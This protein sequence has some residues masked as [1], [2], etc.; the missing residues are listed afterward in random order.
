MFKVLLKKVILKK[1][2]SRIMENCQEKLRKIAPVWRRTALALLPIAAVLF[3]SILD[4]AAA[5]VCAPAMALVVSVQGMVEVR[6]AKGKN[7]QTVLL[8]DPLCP[9]DIIRVRDR[10]RAAV[11]FNNET[12]LR[13]D[14]KTTL[15]LDSAAKGKTTLIE[16]MTGAIHVLTRTPKPFKINTPFLNAGIDGTEFSIE[17]EQDQARLVM[18]EGKVSA[19][20][21][22]GSVILI[23][24]EAV[25]APRN[26]APRKEAVVRP[27]D[28]VQ[29]ALYYPTIINSP[30]DRRAGIEP[31]AERLQASVELYQHGRMTEALAKLDEI[32][33][34]EH[35]PRF[36]TYRAGLLLSVGRVD[37]ARAQIQQAAQLDPRNSNVHALK[38][39]IA[40]VKN[41]KEQARALAARAVELDSFSATARL[42]LS[43]AQQA[44]F[45]IEEAVDSVKRAVE[46][47]PQNAL[48][49]ARLAELHMSN[50]YLDRALG[51][52][53]HAVSLNPHLGKTQTVL[54]FTYLVQIDTGGA[55]AAFS[56]AIELDQADPMPRLGMGLAKIR[57]GDLETGRIE[58]EIAASLD[59]GNSLIRSYL[60]KAYFEEKRYGLA[61]TQ[62]DLAKERD[63]YDPTPWLYDGIMKQ[64]QNQP[65]EALSDIQK[66]I[67]LN[68]NRA[69][70][71]SRLL[72]DQDEAARGSSLARIY[73]NLEFEKRAI[74]E[75][76][77]SLSLDP[78]SHSAHRFLSDT[79]ADIPRH[80]TARISELLQAQLLQPININPVQPRLAVADLNIITSTGPAAA[81]FNEF[82]PLLERNKPQF[83]A[84]GILGSRGTA[85]EEAVFSALYRRASVSLGQFHY[86]T[87]GFRPNNDQ[88][89]NIYNAFF[90]YAVTPKFN[91]QAE[92]R[93]RKSEE[94]DLLLDFM[95]RD[96]RNFTDK[97]RELSEDSVRLGARYSLSPKQD[98]IVS[99][100][101]TDRKDVTI[102][103]PNLGQRATAIIPTNDQGY[104]TE[105][106]YLLRE[107]RFNVTAG[108]GTYRFDV[109]RTGRRDYGGGSCPADRA[110]CDD[111]R[112]EVTR[113]RDNAYIYTNL[114][115]HSKGSAT[116]GLSYDFFKNDI[117]RESY[118]KLI[119]SDSGASFSFA[120]FS[121]KFGLQWDIVRDVRLRLAWFE[122]VKPA[123]V[124]SRTLEPTQVAGFNQFFDDVSGTRARR[125][126]V[127]LD[128]RIADKLYGGFEVSAR[129][130]DVPV[131]SLT[132]WSLSRIVKQQ[133]KLYRTYLYWLPHPHWALR[134]EL[135]FEKYTQARASAI[136]ASDPY[137]IETLSAPLSLN[138]FG[139]SGIFAKLMSTYVQQE[140]NRRSLQNQGSNDFFLLDATIG[141]RLPNRR[142]II[143]LEGR[144]LLNQEFFF[145]NINFQQAEQTFYNQRYSPSRTFFLR[146]TLNF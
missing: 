78:A 61:G 109:E 123:L 4:A 65:V 27:L 15:T 82:T 107:D 99:G 146:L 134:G 96:P 26:E 42:A 23:D 74:M 144:N 6:R 48:A 68:D 121:P 18:H 7:W 38:A 127:G 32:A 2:H 1:N 28:A 43:Y 17:L 117:D 112:A 63:P 9:G 64:T 77:R 25:I 106:Q 103:P 143:S 10:S 51:A 76:A 122:T 95:Y 92:L 20:N 3:S 34:S 98:L 139:P 13:L 129:D 119:T 89:H 71:R 94:G 110:P 131:L 19:S 141:Y 80:N 57:E 114:I 111:N 100:I 50:G 35:T 137:L 125:M 62:F 56:R 124:A 145:R 59:P 142:G 24:T 73:D 84:S 22:H 132:S 75:T 46:I 69:V 39:V 90:Q 116:L 44:H 14:Q 104:Q 58:L 66:S 53:Q 81:G 5:D 47:D 93:T 120:E 87:D 12:M 86:N 113:K 136:R 133:E 91:F 79:Y 8:N 37:E 102:D 128:A 108:G 55:K 138:Y 72:L 101:Y 60:G 33:A 97:R 30:L 67:E 21:P 49:W 70:Y 83:V 31:S 41:D 40:A 36:L 140:V 11:R 105:V 126:G 29:W 54:G 118:S 88:K 52:A 115:L 135:Q 85:G 16:M 130:L 45:E